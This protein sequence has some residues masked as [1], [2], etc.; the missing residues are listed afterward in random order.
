MIAMGWNEIVRI[1]LAASRPRP[2][3]SV[4]IGLGCKNGKKYKFK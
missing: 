4:N 1:Y 2:T 3:F